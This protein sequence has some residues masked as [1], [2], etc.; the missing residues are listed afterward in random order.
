MQTQRHGLKTLVNQESYKQLNFL[1]K[2]KA[3]RFQFQ[4]WLEILNPIFTRKILNKLRKYIFL[5]PS[6]KRAH[7]KLT[8]K[9]ERQAP[10]ILQIK[11]CTGIQKLLES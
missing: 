7:T 2:L 1:Q 5:N 11:L 9:L 4:P 3:T 10:Q 8:V 6:E